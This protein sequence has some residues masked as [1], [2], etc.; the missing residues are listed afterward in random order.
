MTKRTILIGDQ[1]VSTTTA[2]LIMRLIEVVTGEAAITQAIEVI[3]VVDSLHTMIETTTINKRT[4]GSNVVD[5]LHT[6]AEVAETTMVVVAKVTQV[7]SCR[8]FRPLTTK[9][10]CRS[11]SKKLVSSHKKPSFCS[12]VMVNLN[13]QAL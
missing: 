1:A 5:S 9:E 2:T 10:T 4:L 7:F 3:V 12:I 13:V 8:I 11:F 6:K